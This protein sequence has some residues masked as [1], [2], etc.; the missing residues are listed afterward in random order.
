MR[1]LLVGWGLLLGFSFTAIAGGMPATLY[2][3]PH[4]GCCVKYADYLRAN[5]FDVE[6]ITTTELPRIKREHNVPRML[7]ACHTTVVMDFVIEGHVPAQT[8]KRLLKENP[9]IAG[10]AVPG[11]PAG[12]P[13]MTGAKGE[14]LKVY[15]LEEAANPRIYEVH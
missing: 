15:V 4:C 8:I 13:G 12:S 6:V 5:R 11:M 7:E 3:D 14:P 10:V 1:R 2:R 9:K